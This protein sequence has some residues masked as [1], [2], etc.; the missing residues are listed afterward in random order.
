MAQDKLTLDRI[1]QLMRLV[2]NEL[3]KAEDHRGRP[4]D[5]LTAVATAA[6]L[7]P[8]ELAQTETGAVRCAGTP[9]SASTPPT[10]SRPAS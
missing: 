8:Y 3:R 6:Q 5:L 4:K 10:A 9:T 7:T 1:D 2:F